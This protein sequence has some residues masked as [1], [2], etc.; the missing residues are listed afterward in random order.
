MGIDRGATRP[1]S[2]AIDR[3]SRR[4]R[5][6]RTAGLFVAAVTG[7]VGVAVAAPEAGDHRPWPRPA[8]I[9][10]AE[11][12]AA[13]SPSGRKKGD[14]FQE[15][16]LAGAVR[17][18]QHDRPRVGLEAQARIAAKIDQC[19]PADSDTRR[20]IRL[21]VQGEPHHTRMGIS[22]YSVLLSLGSHTT[23]GEAGSAIASSIS[24]PSIWAL[25]S[26]I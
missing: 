15:I 8:A 7:C 23:I 12:G 10:L 11:A 14:R 3:R 9:D 2:K 19:E 18:G 25:M 5:L 20:L 16:G 13:Q 6:I 22:T 21:A 4:T 26:S 17:S 24:S 1:G